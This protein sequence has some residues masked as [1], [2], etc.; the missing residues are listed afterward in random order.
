MNRIKF[1]IACLLLTLTCKSSNAQIVTSNLFLQGKY[2]EIGSQQNASLGSSVNPPA[3]Y[4]PKNSGSPF[5]CGSSSPNFLASV[6]DYGLDGW[7]IG[8][9]AYMG[10]YTLPGSPW[11]GWGIEVNGTR[12]WAYST[13]CN[14]SGGLTPATGTWT[15]YTN[16][17]GQALGY[18][19][20]SFLGGNLLV[21]QEYR[22]DTLSSA[23][24]VT[25]KLKNVGTTTLNNVYY[26]RSC[27]PDNSVPWGGSFTTNNVIRFQND[28]YHR[29][30]VSA[31]S[32]GPVG[33]I[34][35]PATVLSLGTKDA[36]AK[37]L[38]F[39]SWPLSTTATYSGI[40]AGTSGGIGTSYY[41]VNTGAVND[42]A[43]GLVFNLCNILPGDSTMCSYAYIYNSASSMVAS[44]DTAF[45]EPQLTANGIVLDSV[46]T[47]TACIGGTTVN[48]N[49]L[50]G[51]DKS[52]SWS[53][54]TWSPSTGLSS[55]TGT[56][57]ILNY[58]GI[59][60]IT[61]YTITGDDTT[62]CRQLHKQ[63]LLTVIPISAATPI[64][65]DT[66]YCQNTTPGL[67]TLNV[68]YTGT[69]T[70]YTTPTGGVGTTITPTISTTTPGVTTYYVTQ[71]VAGCESARVPLR[72]TIN[73]AYNINLPVSICNGT[74][75]NY[76]GNIYN[77]AGTY[78]NH[79]N[80]ILGCDSTM[81]VV[82][83][84]L[85]TDTIR[86]LDS[87]CQGDEYAF[88]GH[89]YNSNGTYVLSYT[90]KSG[91]DS[92]MIL[93]LIVKP[94][95]E[96]D[97]KNLT[98]SNICVGDSIRIT[99][100]NQ[101]Y[102]PLTY[103]WTFD[104][105]STILYNVNPSG[106]YYIK[107]NTPGSYN[108]YLYVTNDFCQSSLDS[109]QIQ[110]QKYPDASIKEP[111]YNVCIGDKIFFEPL[112]PEQ[113]IIYY[114]QPIYYFENESA[115]GQPNIS[116]TVDISRTV[117]L[118][119][120]SKFGCISTDSV[121]VVAHSCCQFVIPNSFTPNADGNND[122]YTPIFTGNGFKVHV[123][124]IFNRWGNEVYSSKLLATKGWDGMYKN[125]PCE[126]GV[127]YW[128]IDYEC[129][130]VKHTAKGDVT[131]IR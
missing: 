70:W 89:T 43:I 8:T 29:V 67:I 81:N 112:N 15:L 50:H 105:P 73:P 102:G 31:T 88:S 12:E 86:V 25:V 1:L 28:F 19:N 34:G 24:V 21:N 74:S 103:H 39:T 20:G 55:T 26:L 5:I 115:S 4:H 33:S 111:G 124:S 125:E 68:T 114:W 58:A 117:I 35:T 107:Y 9:P 122:L 126:V 129:E 78:V 99:S 56:S 30:M 106:P 77:A 61:T 83:T 16:S 46:D 54:W 22:V 36:R 52:W 97:I 130:G 49:V 123:F 64:T 113:G 100:I 62:H 53:G 90:N 94:L 127:Y 128:Y 104:L 65:R 6:Y 7:T 108:I 38:I 3:G 72:V 18:W 121:Q 76:Y 2:L 98:S 40:W 109:I 95:P 119:A 116:G 87:V 57:T 13:N 110:V 42:I 60:S 47:I 41:T 59:S 45:P 93:T 63:F 51:S 82:V 91:C 44:L 69:L 101:A 92:T 131:L 17:G 14:L 80:T 27:D 96:A 84:I 10:D 120:L 66:F 48:L 32:T 11:E 79:F 37:C 75:Y 118:H 23:L 71:T 85:P